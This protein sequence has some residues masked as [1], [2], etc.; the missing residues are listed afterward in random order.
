MKRSA[1]GLILGVVLAFQGCAG[2]QLREDNANI[3]QVR[4][5]KVRDYQDRTVVIIEGQTRP[6]YTV[7]KLSEPHRIVIDMAGTTIGDSTRE[8]EKS[9]KAMI[10]SVST[11]QFGDGVNSVARVEL[12]MPKHA[13]YGTAVKDR[14]LVVTIPK[15]RTV[16][17]KVRTSKGTVLTQQVELQPELDDFDAGFEE[18]EPL[19][20]D[21]SEEILFDD[22]SADLLLPDEPMLLI[23]EKPVAPLEPIASPAPRQP[24]SSPMLIS[25]EDEGAA[26]ARRALEG[27]AD[28]PEEIFMEDPMDDELPAM[29]AFEEP[30]PPAPI[31]TIPAPVK[32]ASRDDSKA[33]KILDVKVSSTSGATK[34]LIVTDGEIGA[35]NAFTLE[36]PTRLVIDIWDTGNLYSAKEVAINASGI[37]VLRLGQQPDRV[38][39][40]LDATQASLPRYNVTKVTNGLQIEV[41]GATVE[42]KPSVVMQAPPKAAPQPAAAVSNQPA[43]APAVQASTREVTTIRRQEAPISKSSLSEDRSRKTYTGRRVSLDFQ[44][45]NLRD[46]LRLIAEVSNLNIITAQDVAGTLSLRLINVPWD[47]ALDV[48]LD[49]QGLGMVRVGNVVRI[50]KK[51]IL[52]TEERAR[53]QSIKESAGL[54]PLFVKIVP[55]NYASASELAARVQPVLSERGTVAVDNRTN[56]LIIKDIAQNIDDV[57]TLV[58]NLDTQTPQVLIEAKIVEASTNFTQDLGIQW[59]GN[60]N[61]GPQFGTGTGLQFPNSIGMTGGNLGPTGAPASPGFAVNLPAAAGP[62]AGGAMSFLFGSMNNAAVLDLRLSALES[63]GHG[64]VISSPR[65]TT[66]NKSQASIQ[67]G[68]SIPFETTSANGTQTQFIDAV[69]KLTVTPQITPDRSVIMQIK[70]EK[71]APETSLRSAGGAPSISKKEATTEVLVKDGE[72]T[73]I[74]GIFQISKSQS[75]TGVPFFSKIPVLGWFFKKSTMEDTRSE[76]LIF[77]TPRIVTPKDAAQTAHAN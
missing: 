71:N 24:A 50:A 66:L 15:Y 38:R 36:G 3:N 69:I 49:S 20:L 2:S 65:I 23:E 37:K 51:D 18:L 41:G 39:L 26:L 43:A 22:P 1:I 12:A 63:S 16:T 44:N 47:Q 62:G 74:G 30:V 4:T 45:A 56:V 17:R 53:L 73:V 14:R 70:A 75:R 40:V 27:I 61:A 46:I 72:T 60:Y 35:Y 29:P 11:R 57:T 8:L 32:A 55:V 19:P 76:L 48:I 10:R 13:Q 33:A 34:I 25:E 58:E 21:A 31:R 5:V 52:A 42:A 67:Q 28:E 77:I 6:T 9:P 54:E 64:R 59:G 7:F 68:I